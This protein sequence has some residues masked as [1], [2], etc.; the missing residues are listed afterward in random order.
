MQ[1][2]IPA[3][4]TFAMLIGLGTPTAMADDSSCKQCCAAVG[5]PNCSTSLRIVGED[6]L[7]VARGTAGYEVVG[8][9]VAS[10]NGKAWFDIDQTAMFSDEPVVGEVSTDGVLPA[11]LRCFSEAC[12][13]PANTCPQAVGTR[14]VLRRCTDGAPVTDAMLAVAGAKPPSGVG[15]S[16]VVIDGRPIVVVKGT[17]ASPPPATA[18][19][20]ASGYNQNATASSGYS[21]ATPPVSGAGQ[22]SGYGQTA[23]AQTTTSSA[24]PASAY[25]Q[26]AANSGQSGTSYAQPATGY[27]QSATN[28]A[29]PASGYNNQ[30]ATAPT[31]Q[32]DLSIPKSPPSTCTTAD[33]LVKESRK[34]VDMG[35][36]AEL[37]NELDRAA[38]E[39][40]AA[41]TLY[42][43]NGFAWAALGSL[44]LR[45]NHPTEAVSALEVARKLQPNHYGAA[46]DL[47]KAY[48]ALG[49][50]TDAIGAYQAA[51]KAN[52]GYAPASQ[53]LTRLG[54]APR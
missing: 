48:E 41:I 21:Q 23:T 47:G 14:P 37:V 42:P 2:R 38:D 25:G 46:T 34:H 15:T 6:S 36:D 49:K 53:A 44:A 30:V 20:V 32:V 43:C 8:M 35:N 40:R 19:G 45:T 13:F 16:T 33:A 11:T 29:Q 12:S 52:P 1:R 51:L 22:T 10:C 50:K 31:P 24:P 7:I 27:S 39:Y 17:A 4:T 5:A 9:W 18:S 26:T 28:Y 3:L 54:V